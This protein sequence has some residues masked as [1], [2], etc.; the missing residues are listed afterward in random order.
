VP[1]RSINLLFTLHLHIYIYILV[2]FPA[3]VSQSEPVDWLGF[4]RLGSPDTTLRDATSAKPAAAGDKPSTM[5]AAVK[6]TGRQPETVEEQPAG[7]TSGSSRT[8]KADKGDSR[9][10]K[11]LDDKT[12]KSTLDWLEMAADRSTERRPPSAGSRKSLD[13]TQDDDWLGIKTQSATEKTDSASDYLG[14]GAEIDFSNKPLRFYFFSHHLLFQTVCHFSYLFG[15]PITT[16]LVLVVVIVV[17]GEIIFKK[18]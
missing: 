15:C 13:S 2:L 12:E 10:G 4:S 1:S 7:R 3:A 16:H 9:Q 6:D 17:V 8:P 14:L 18:A 11:L 5:V